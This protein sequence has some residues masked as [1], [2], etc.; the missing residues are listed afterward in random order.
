MFRNKIIFNTIISIL[1]CSMLVSDPFLQKNFPGVSQGILAL[2]FLVFSFLDYKFFRNNVFIRASAIY[3]SIILILFILSGAESYVLFSN[4]FGTVLFG[5]SV[6]NSKYIDRV[7]Q[8]SAVLILIG[9]SIIGLSFYFNL[10]EIDVLTRRYTFID[11][12]QNTLA[13]LLCIGISFIFYYYHSAK[14]SKY[15]FGYL[16][17]VSLL[18]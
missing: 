2:P 3:G 13:Q 11:H 12:N 7:F 9:C 6:F 1:V 5:L 10:W 17:L 14:S 15:K 4:T 18:S 8:K 16:I